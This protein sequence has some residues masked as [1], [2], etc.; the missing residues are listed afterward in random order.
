MPTLKSIAV[1]CASS[2]GNH[3]KYQEIAAKTGQY[4]AH[5]AIELVYGGGN[6]GL[7]GS[8]SNACMN[9]GGKVYGVI[10]HFFK[11]REVTHPNITRLEY[12]DTMHQRKWKIYEASDAFIILPGGLG[13]MDEFFEILTW[14]QIGIHRKPIGILNQDGFYD[15]LIQF[16][17]KMVAEGFVKKINIALICIESSIEKLVRKL[18][19][20]DATSIPRFLDADEVKA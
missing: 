12:V 13:T 2:E 8:L 18:E 20:F 19:K 1:F 10:P 17:E 15:L 7:M 11:R 6:V 16:I 3:P 4:F 9:A 14:A 5:N